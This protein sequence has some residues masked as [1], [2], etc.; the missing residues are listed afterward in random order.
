MSNDFVIAI[1]SGKGGT[2][3]TTIATNLAHIASGLGRKVQYL[4]CDVEEPNGHIFL[5]PQITGS[6][7]I[8][9]D[10]PQVNPEKCTACSKCGEICQYG[11]IVCIKEH[12]LTFEQL[13]HSCG[14]CFRIC[15]TDA[16]KAKTLKIGDIE[17][18]KSVE[19]EFVG[20]KLQ[21]GN[22]HTPALIKEVKK[23][24]KQ[25]SLVIIDVPPGT[26]C[27]VVEAVKGVDFVLL[28]TEPTP[29]GLNDLRMAV[30]LANEM[31]LPF[32]VV[33]N[34]YGIGNEEVEKYCKAEN[35]D[36]IMRLPD[37]RRIAEAYSSGKMIIEQ[38]PEYKNYFLNLLKEIESRR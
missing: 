31:N 29:F 38:L 5:K 32:D 35:I 21:I 37:D 27:P 2:G 8:T 3:K 22:V 34:R 13:C 11:A 23:Q 1:A 7:E 14:G 18:G 20:G 6:Q 4:D 9:V 28:V 33:I 25:D 12:V 17:F 26:S 15:P 36:I 10:V 19:I 30:E 24:I 16:I